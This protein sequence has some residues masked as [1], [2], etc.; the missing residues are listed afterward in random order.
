M[1]AYATD[2]TSNLFV[3]N[4]FSVP[5]DLR[6]YWISVDP[7]VLTVPP[8]GIQN[9]DVSLDATNMS[10]GDYNDYFVI[11]S[12]D[13]DNSILEVPVSLIAIIGPDFALPSS[14]TS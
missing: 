4:E 8:G 14:F 12:N 9:L 10:D 5:I 1:M 2:P 6:G 13:F 3:S 7:L 11:N